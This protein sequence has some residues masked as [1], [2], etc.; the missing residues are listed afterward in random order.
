MFCKNCG[1]EIKDNVD[2]CPNCGTAV[3]KTAGAAGKKGFSV[4]ML[5]FEVGRSSIV[6]LAACVVMI[7]M[8]F[9]PYVSVEFWGMSESQ[10]LI[11]GGDG[12]FFIIVVLIGVVTGLMGKEKPMIVVGAIACLLML[13]E[14][15]NFS[16]SL[17]DI[18][19][20]G[21]EDLVK[22][23]I[24]FYLMILSSI[25]LLAAPFVKKYLKK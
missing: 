5:K 7:L 14:V 17:K 9:L 10:S 4:D 8:V 16:N 13:F 24:G 20:Y 2:F 18:K 12:F 19:S 25:A 6:A 15:F 1:S 21:L 23:G 3:E 11:K 22:R